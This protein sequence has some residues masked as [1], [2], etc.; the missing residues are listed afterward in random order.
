MCTLERITRPKKNRRVSFSLADSEGK[1]I[2]TTL[3]DIEECKLVRCSSSCLVP[4]SYVNSLTLYCKFALGLFCLRMW[5][6]TRTR[7]ESKSRISE[8]GSSCILKGESAI[9]DLLIKPAA[10]MVG[11]VLHLP[12]IVSRADPALFR[13]DLYTHVFRMLTA[14]RVDALFPEPTVSYHPQRRRLRCQWKRKGIN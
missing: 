5:C 13:S 14:P 9:V 3:E 7:R 1:E 10:P 11:T 4:V 6:R 2:V 12:R 8:E